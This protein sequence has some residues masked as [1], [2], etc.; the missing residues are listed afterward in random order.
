MPQDLEHWRTK[1]RDAGLGFADDPITLSLTLALPALFPVRDRR[2]TE[3]LLTALPGF[4]ARLYDVQRT[5]DVLSPVESGDELVREALNAYGEPDRGADVLVDAL[6]AVAAPDRPSA[7]ESLC[8][9]TSVPGIAA[10]AADLALSQALTDD[11]DAYL[12]ALAQATTS[13]ED[14][15]RLVDLLHRAFPAASYEVAVDAYLRLPRQDSRLASAIAHIALDLFAR[16]TFDTDP[17]PA[18]EP[19][20]MLDLDLATRMLDGER[21]EQAAAFAHRAAGNAHSQDLRV[22]ALVVLSRAVALLG[23]HW[24]AREKADEAVAVARGVGDKGLLFDALQTVVASNHAVRDRSRAAAASLEALEL[25]RKLEPED[26]AIALGLACA[27]HTGEPGRAAE[28][29]AESVALLRDMADRD[30]GRHLLRYIAALDTYATALS[31]AGQDAFDVGQ[32]ALLLIQDLHRLDPDRHGPQYAQV[33]LNFSNRLA[34]RGDHANALEGYLTATRVLYALVPQSP[35]AYAAKCAIATWSMA[36]AFAALH[37]WSE[38]EQ[39]I[40]GTITLQRGCVGESQPWVIPDLLDSLEF[41]KLCLSR[42]KRFA[43]L[44]ALEK[45]QQ[46][47]RVVHA[48]YQKLSGSAAPAPPDG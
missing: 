43:E 11:P 3:A 21:P 19:S 32:Q 38:A 9:L 2:S 34:A 37:R 4:R 17:D 42:A 29:A 28:F 20:P 10:E 41:L 40:L 16:K 48:R 7:V 39:A 26:Q 12:P 18:D 36:N 33:V 31:A 13:A 5:A 30:P 47:L 22:R 1:V 27:A 25:S 14:P 15:A 35:H 44:P 46:V 8:R 6:R 45:E 24:Y 23:H